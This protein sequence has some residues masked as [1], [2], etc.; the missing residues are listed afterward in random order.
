VVQLGM[1]IE[2]AKSWHISALRVR[3]FGAIVSAGF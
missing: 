3:A 2:N 1:R